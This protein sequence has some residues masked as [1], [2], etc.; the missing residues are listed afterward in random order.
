MAR[1]LSINLLHRVLEAMREGAS[2]HATVERSRIA[3]A[4]A[5]RWP[6]QDQA[7]CSDPLPMGEDRRSGPIEPQAAFLKSLVD[8]QDDIT[9]HEMRRRLAVDRGPKVGIHALWRSFDRHGLT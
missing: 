6:S 1:A 9:L 4:T 5:V 8:G 7:G 3:I 2:S